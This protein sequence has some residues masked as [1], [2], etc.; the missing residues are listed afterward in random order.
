MRGPDDMQNDSQPVDRN[1]ARTD[2]LAAM[3]ILVITVVLII[4]VVTRLI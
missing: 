1:K 4:V 3:G 2:G